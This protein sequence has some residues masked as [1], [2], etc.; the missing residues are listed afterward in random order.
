MESQEE[1]IWKEKEITEQER[2][3]TKEGERKGKDETF[4]E[5]K[6]G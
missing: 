3:A 1:E 6:E 4:R 2:R 5:K